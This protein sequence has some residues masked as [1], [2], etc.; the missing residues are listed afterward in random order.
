MY[1]LRAYFEEN[2]CQIIE[3]QY[4]SKI[5]DA[6]IWEIELEYNLILKIGQNTKLEKTNRGKF[7]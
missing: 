5:E 2:N 6:L 7:R 3:C 1:V 4:L